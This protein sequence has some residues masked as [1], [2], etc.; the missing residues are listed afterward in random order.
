[1]RYDYA[2]KIILVGD[3]N[4]G[5]SY[6]FNKLAERPIDNISST[7]GVD[8]SI[9]YQTIYNKEFRINL[10]D[11]AGQERFYC[12]V[13]NYFRN[14]SGFILFFDVNEP[15]SFYALQRWI[16][17]IEEQNNCC[18]E[19]PMILIGNK[20]DLPHKINQNDIIDFTEKYNLTYVE[21]SLKENSINIKDILEI[22]VN[23]IYKTLIKSDCQFICSNIKSYKDHHTNNKKS[24]INYET[25]ASDKNWIKQMQKYFC[26]L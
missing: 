16:N 5:K 24:L 6:F 13:N 15:I 11:T 21:M 20:N 23:K 18:H 2:L 19:H 8:F 12:I 7:I 9:I 26:F 25:T 1:M 14:I 17:K 22:L 4:T 3:S 10:W